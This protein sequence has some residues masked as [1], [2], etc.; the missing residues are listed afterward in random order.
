MKAVLAQQVWTTPR[1][2]CAQVIPGT[3][4][5]A[6]HICIS[7]DPY[8]SEYAFTFPVTDDDTEA[9][10]QSNL[11]G[12]AILMWQSQNMGPGQLAPKYV[13]LTPSY[14]VSHWLNRRNLYS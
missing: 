4:S 13:S 14:T 12:H 8:N 5:N 11:P 9:E 6:L 2:D 3:A 1:T 10:R 7:Q